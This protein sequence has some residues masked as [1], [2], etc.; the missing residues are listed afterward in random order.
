M[1]GILVFSGSGPLLILSSYPTIDHPD[2]IARLKAKGLEKFMAWEIPLERCRHLYGFS[3]R[4][5]VEDLATGNDI[6]VLDCDGHHIFLNF[7]LREL[8]EGVVYEAERV[9]QAA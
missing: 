7:S 9:T 8:G 5:I 3:Y 4:D 2:L 6:R 1:K